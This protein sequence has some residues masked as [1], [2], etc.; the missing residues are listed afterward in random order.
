MK[1]GCRFCNTATCISLTASTV[2]PAGIYI[3]FRDIFV[4]TLDASSMISLKLLALL[5]GLNAC[6]ARECAFFLLSQT[7]S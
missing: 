2:Y 5:D 6:K 3:L 4:Y 7:G 1:E